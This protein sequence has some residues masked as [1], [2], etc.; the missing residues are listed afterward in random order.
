MTQLARMSQVTRTA[1]MPQ[2]ADLKRKQ[3]MTMKRSLSLHQNR[4]KPSDQSLISQQ[5]PNSLRNLNGQICCRYLQLLR[6]SPPYHRP[7]TDQFQGSINPLMLE[8]QFNLVRFA[9]QVV[10]GTGTQAIIHHLTGCKGQCGTIT[11]QDGDLA[12]VVK[13]GSQTACH[14]SKTWVQAHFSAVLVQRSLSNLYH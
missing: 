7:R 13:T 6:Q 2:P 12:H 1:R 3:V 5:E 11:L 10:G 4:S 14:V 8:W 9:C